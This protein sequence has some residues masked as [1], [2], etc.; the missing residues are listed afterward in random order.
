MTRDE[1]LTKLMA[2]T[3]NACTMSQMADFLKMSVALGMLKLDDPQKGHERAADVLFA[4]AV[5][6]LIT[7]RHAID[8]LYAAGLKIVEAH[9]L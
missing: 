1:A 4:C 7:P 6:G 5:N 2:E 8:A 9:G 3:S